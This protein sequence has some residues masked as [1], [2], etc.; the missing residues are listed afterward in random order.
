[1]KKTKHIKKNNTTDWGCFTHITLGEDDTIGMGKYY[2]KTVREVI[3]L[4]GKVSIYDIL[5]YYDVEEDILKELHIHRL[6]SEE[7]EEIKRVEQGNK[8]QEEVKTPVSVVNP[9]QEMNYGYPEQE[10]YDGGYWV[11]PVDYDPEDEGGYGCPW[12]YRN[13]NRIRVFESINNQ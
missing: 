10:E 8:V 6:T 3:T 2:G 1:M 13:N 7:K 4:Y 5:R 11:Y 12:G 9:T